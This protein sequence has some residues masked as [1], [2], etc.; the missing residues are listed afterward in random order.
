MALEPATLPSAIESY[1]AAVA[2][3]ARTTTSLRDREVF[4]Q[5]LSDG[6]SILNLAKSGANAESLLYATGKHQGIWNKMWL[7]DPVYEGPWK[8]WRGISDHVGNAI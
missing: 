8:L 3:A 6:A 2:E 1:I 5:L 7:E 4:E